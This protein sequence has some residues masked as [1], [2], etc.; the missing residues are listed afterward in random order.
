MQKE[1]RTP[2][3]YARMEKKQKYESRG[4]IEKDRNQSIRELED[5][6]G[7]FVILTVSIYTEIYILKD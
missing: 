3:K 6:W 5:K 2:F 1:L 7:K 4:E